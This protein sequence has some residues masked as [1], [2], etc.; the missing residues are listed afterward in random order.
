[1]SLPV[2]VGIGCKAT[3]VLVVPVCH[4][5]VIGAVNVSGAPVLKLKIPPTPQFSV[6]RCIHAAVLPSNALLAPNGN[7]YVPVLLN[8]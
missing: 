1:M 6:T 4:N 5:D 2:L 7:M 3:A 8:T